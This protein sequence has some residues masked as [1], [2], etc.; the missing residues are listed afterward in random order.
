[1]KKSEVKETI[2]KNSR[3]YWEHQIN[4]WIHDEIDRKI[5]TLFLLD[6]RLLKDIADVVGMEY[7]NMYR[8]YKKAIRQLL[9]H[10]DI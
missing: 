5:L 7:K 8:R 2:D 10:S 4:E 1:M 6:G 9:K 3:S